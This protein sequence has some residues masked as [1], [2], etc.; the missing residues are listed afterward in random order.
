MAEPVKTQF[1]IGE[2]SIYLRIARLDEGYLVHDKG[3]RMIRGI[4][5]ELL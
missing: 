4:Y 3:L 2:E 5:A 1:S